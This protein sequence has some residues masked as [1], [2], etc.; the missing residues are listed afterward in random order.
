MA[1]LEQLLEQ[2]K[3]GR[4]VRQNL[5]EIRQNISD[6]SLRRRFMYQLGGDFSMLTDLLGS[7]DPKVRKNAALILGMTED[8]DVLPALFDAWEKEETLFVRQDYLKAISTLDYREYLPRLK[9]RIREIS[10]RIGDEAEQGSMDLPG[11]GKDETGKDAKTLPEHGIVPKMPSEA[12]EVSKMQSETGEAEEKPDAASD[13]LLWDNSAHLLAELALLRKMAGRYEKRG[14]HRFIKMN[15]APELML[16]T[17]LLHADVTARQVSHGTVR[18]MRGSVHVK[19]GDLNE[20][21]KIRTWTECLFPISSARPILG[22]EKLIAFRLRDLKI[23]NYLNYLHED[24]GLPYRYRIELKSTSIP[25]EKKGEY[26]R[27]I[28][29]RLDV[30]EKG[31]L[32]NTESDYEV[33]LRLIERADHSVIPMLRLFTLPDQRFAYRKETTAQSTAAPLAALAAELARPYLKE[34]AQVLDPFCGAATLLI[35]RCLAVP[36]DPVY[37]IDHLAEAIGKAKENSVIT[38]QVKHAPIHFINRDFFDFTHEYPFDEIITHLPEVQP[39]EAEQFAI[40][41][42]EKA[43]GLLRGGAVLIILTNTPAALK[44]A[45]SGCY[46]LLEEYLLNERT[47]ST[48]LIFRH[49]RDQTDGIRR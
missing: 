8:E 5:I 14:K 28:A 18:V 17:N 24:N 49:E 30:L 23:G 38:E 2:I 22:D 19:G 48:E 27:R 36:A 41:F 47:G 29:S 42:L 39:E 43:S 32:L 1:R 6:E 34:G 11:A 44:K 12:A 31:K 10:G 40:R 46:T 35:E 20:I 16:R 25:R 4:D 37:G 3:K 15:P 26:I 45:A 33:E 21:L 13:H 7:S 9:E